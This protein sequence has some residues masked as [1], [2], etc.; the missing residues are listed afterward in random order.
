M[1]TFRD[2]I[3]LGTKVPQMKT[4]DYN[5]KSVTTA[6]LAD[7][8]VTSEKI[9]DGTISM[10]NLAD[11]LANKISLSSFH[12]SQFKTATSVSSLPNSPNDI[13]W[14]VANHLYLYVGEDNQLYAD[15][16]ELRGAQGIQGEKGDTGERGAIGKSAY[17]L[18]EEQD[19]NSG[20]SVQSFLNSLKGDKGDK[21][22]KGAKGD[23]FTFADLTAREIAQLKGEK[24]DAG[25]DGSDGSDGI[26]GLTITNIEQTT[27]S[28]ESDGINVITITRSDGKVFP[29]QIKNGS[30]GQNGD[31]G[32]K[33]DQGIQGEQ[34]IQGI[35]GEKGEKGDTGPQGVAGPQGTSGV[36]D[37]S[38]KALV[39]DVVTGGE[40]DFLSAEVGKLGIVDYDVSKGGT[41]TVATLQ[42]AIN[43]VP[44]TFRKG[45]LSILYLETNTL[46]YNKY[47]LKRRDWSYDPSDWSVCAVGLAQEEGDS[48]TTAVSQKTFTDMMKTK[49]D[50]AS[51]VDA[52]SDDD[53][54]GDDGENEEGTDE[55]TKVE[56]PT[57]KAVKD[58]VATAKESINSSVE[59]NNT[60]IKEDMDAFKNEV[61]NKITDIQDTFQ[62]TKEELY[63]NVDA[64]MQELTDAVDERVSAVP[65]FLAMSESEYDSLEDKEEDTY[66]MLYEEG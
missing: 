54:T 57:S 35:Q 2:D 48:T 14:I 55:E 11:E 20:K 18:W 21:G 31:K 45:G 4:D 53:S 59:E 42:D 25:K 52:I 46:T 44:T 40:T 62:A 50:V 65:K 23:S 22:D 15:C 43:S 27:L 29:F 12:V 64:K 6:K 26:D 32:D 39:N 34:G 7:K 19:G 3:R 5:D 28:T 47:I 41:A 30:R 61:D 63:E 56:V 49:V 10:S 24:G 60:A 9:A 58:Y 8:S 1:P 37:A 38:D 33:G 51:L 13:G 16:G 17:E 66:Y 36:S